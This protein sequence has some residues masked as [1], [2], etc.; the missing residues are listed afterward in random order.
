R[1]R[2]IFCTRKT[3][4]ENGDPED[5]RKPG[6]AHTPPSE[7]A[8]QGQHMHPQARAYTESMACSSS[9]RRRA[10]LMQTSLV[11]GLAG[12]TACGHLGI[13]FLPAIE[14]R[15]DASS[16]NDGGADAP[17]GTRSDGGADASIDARADAGVCEGPRCTGLYVSGDVGDDANS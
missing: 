7:Q 17:L 2:R 1:H 12:L 9:L 3:R 16:I 8:K 14:D 4:H 11:V 15:A 6:S 5:R 13:D 10:R